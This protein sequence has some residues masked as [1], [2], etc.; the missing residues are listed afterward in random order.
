MKNLKLGIIIL[1]TLG[2]LW[3]GCHQDEI[4]YLITE[5]ASYGVDSLVIRKN[6]D[7]TEPVWGPNPEYQQYLD[8]GYTPEDIAIFFPNVKPE[9]WINAGAD[10]FRVKNNQPWTGSQIEGIEGSAPIW[11]KVK[12][13]QTD[14][15]DATKLLECVTVRGNGI[16]EVPLENDI[17]VGRYLISLTVWNE[18]WSKDINDCF[19][20]IVK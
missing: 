7:T 8:W 18:G 11:L 16:I 9:T 5:Y 20:I 13:A 6:L 10:Y 17:P 4:G 15:G 14:T 19:T 2:G 1:F 3:S 12:S